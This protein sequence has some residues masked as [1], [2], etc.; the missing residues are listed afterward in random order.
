M[1][2][3]VYLII[4]SRNL[5]F[6]LKF[7][8]EEFSKN[9]K[10]AELAFKALVELISK[11]EEGY[12][13][14]QIVYTKILDDLDLFSFNMIASLKKLIKFDETNEET[15]RALLIKGLG[16]SLRNKIL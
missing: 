1:S 16:G 4:T 13:V 2:L 9:V 8:K 15:N 11:R 3:F 14:D 12:Q 5:N 6:K 10:N 7:K